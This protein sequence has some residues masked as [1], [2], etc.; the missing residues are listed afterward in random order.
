MATTRTAFLALV[1]STCLHPGADY[2]DDCMVEV[3]ARPHGGSAR[4]VVRC[5][6]THTTGHVPAQAI[7]PIG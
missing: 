3:V 1:Q 7:R 6:Y 5:L 2:D 4:A